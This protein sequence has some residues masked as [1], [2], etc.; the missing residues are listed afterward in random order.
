M[1]FIENDASINVN[2]ENETAPFK[3]KSTFQNHLSLTLFN[4]EVI[5]FFLKFNF[6]QDL[7]CIQ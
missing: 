5:L 1:S 7:Y 4:H 6:Y 2:Q 3:A